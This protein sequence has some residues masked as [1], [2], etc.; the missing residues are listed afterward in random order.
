MD[1]RYTL[2]SKKKFDCPACNSTGRFVKYIDVVTGEYLEGDYGKCDRV[3]SCGYHK[4][5]PTQY[6][7]ENETRTVVDEEKSLFDSS[8]Y[9]LEVYDTYHKN[10]SKIPNTFLRGIGNRFGVEAAV[11]AY[12][13][14]Q[15]GTFVDGSVIFPYFFYGKLKS[16]KIMAYKKDLHRD[17]DK[18]TVWLHNFG[19]VTFKL[20]GNN[21]LSESVGSWF[22]FVMPLF[23]WDLLEKYPD[24]KICLVESEKTA[25]I[26]SVVFPEYNWLA[27]GGLYGLQ[28]YKF[29]FYS[30]HTWRV[31]PDLGYMKYK[32]KDMRVSDYWKMRIGE[33]NET[34]TLIDEYPNYMPTAYGREEIKMAEKMQL[35]LADFILLDKTGRYIEHMK[36][37]LKIY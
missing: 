15:L 26:A 7:G 9:P 8:D 23:G 13:L 19:N 18:P 37:I 30:G 34:Y 4:I 21:I 31:F 36:E 24:K 35:D 25:V 16:G 20:P 29:T 6:V 27:T 17:K 33:I 11:N 22:N 1:F 32:G 14:Y 5:P 10:E 12:N 3:E 2:N 28:R